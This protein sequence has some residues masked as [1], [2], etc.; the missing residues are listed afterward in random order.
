MVEKLF[1]DGNYFG[2]LKDDKREGLG[3]MVNQD[4]DFFVGNWKN[5]QKKGFGKINYAN[6]DF[7]EGEW[8]KNKR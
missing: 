3:Q 1:D 2:Q 5:D 6:L 8:N 4:G 7:Y